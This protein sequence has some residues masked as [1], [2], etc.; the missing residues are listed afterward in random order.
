MGAS[1]QSGET[2]AE[3][4]NEVRLV[5]RVSAAPEEV[6][7]PS[8]DVL[9]KF[10]VTVP[11]SVVKAARQQVDALECGAWLARAQRAART[12]TVGDV[13]EVE[14]PVRRRFFRQAGGAPAS[15]VEVEMLRGRRI[16]RSRGA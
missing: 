16:S 15:R 2:T 6:V 12:W 8:G 7:M 5:G 4:F 10:R 3:W 9:V 1:K 13:V 11:R 14:G